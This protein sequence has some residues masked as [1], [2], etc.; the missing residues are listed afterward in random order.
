[1]TSNN[2]FSRF[3]PAGRG[4][5]SFYEELR[6]DEGHG[7]HGGF[8]VEDGAGLALD[9]ENLNEQF[10]DYDLDHADGLGI[11]G[12]RTTVDEGAAAGFGGQR[13]AATATATTAAART[14]RE[15]TA[16]TTAARGGTAAR[17]L[18][19]PRANVSRS[20]WGTT[21]AGG[22]GGGGTGDE[23]G[24]NDDVPGSLLVE[25][26]GM[27]NTPL[28]PLLKATPLRS[29]ASG[30]SRHFPSS[31]AGDGPLP[32]GPTAMLGGGTKKRREQWEAT[33]NVQRLYG[34]DLDDGGAVGGGGGGGLGLRAGLGSGGGGGTGGGSGGGGGMPGHALLSYFFPSGGSR[35]RSTA[36][37]RA[38]WRWVNVSNLDNFIRD[39]YDYYRDCGLRCIL[40]ERFLHL[41]NVAFVAVF[42]TFLT[43]CI[44]YTKI[45]GSTT[46][47]QILVPQC[48]R[49]MSWLWNVGLWLFAFYFVWKLMQFFIFDVRRLLHLRD[50][51]VHLLQIPEHD[52]QTVSWQDVVVKIMALRDQNP[53]TATNLTRRQRDWVGSQSK[54]RLDAHDIA[55]RLMRRENYL[56]ALFNKDILDLT[57]PLPF[58]RR[59]SSSSSSNSKKQ[60]LTRTLEWTLWFGVLDFVF[61]A[62]GQ[63][64][65][66]F[67][68]ASRRSQ[69]SQ[70]LKSRF[71]FAGFMNLLLAPFVACY[72]VVVYFLT[73]YNEYQKNPS[74]LGARAYTPLAEWK[75]REFNELE[76]LFEER[77]NMSYPFA[78]RYLD[79]F[80]KRKTEQVAKTVAF[81]AGSVM[82]VLAIASLFDPELFLGFEITHDRT[83]L[84]Y[85]G[86]FA[87]VWAAARGMITEE[88]SVFD[89]EYALRNVIEYTHYE[90]D[91]WKGR[92]HSYDVK[93]EFAELYQIKIK[94]FLEEIL[95]IFFTPLILFTSLPRSSDQIIDF[96]REFT[97]HVDG[98]GY[99]CSF[100]VFD[101]HKGVGGGTAK[102]RH[103]GPPP[104]EQQQ[105][106]QQQQQQ[107]QEPQ[108]QLQPDPLGANGGDVRDDY[109]A[110]K[111]GKMA[112]SYYGF[113]DNYV[114]NPKTGIPGHHP[115]GSAAAR[116]HHHHHHAQFHPPPAFPGL[117]SP[118]LAADMQSSILRNRKGAGSSVAALRTPRFGPTA[119]VA[120]PSPMASILLDPHHQPSASALFA[121]Q[122]FRAAAAAPGVV[123]GA[124][125]GITSGRY[126]AGVGG[127]S[128]IIEES[129]TE[130]GS[131][132]TTGG[133]PRP[134]SH[135]DDHEEP[136]PPHS[137]EGGEHSG[138]AL[139]DESTWQ[140]SPPTGMS[141]ENSSSS[142]GG[143]GDEA[144]VGVLG[145]MYQFQQAH[146]NHRMGGVR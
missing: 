113:L 123:G 146:K 20:R 45:R 104:H 70:M 75:F 67:L 91:H 49:H 58:L 93:V 33:Q 100:A 57:I 77:L 144:D 42:L 85:V 52:M 64:N 106:Q 134:T 1:M 66:E 136:L 143:V 108:S 24:D 76:H 86:I 18:G 51:Y 139:L 34:D 138:T 114:I 43:Q 109:Y 124:A 105:Q 140:T 5:R 41:V 119:S 120:Q 94:I 7:E 48:T 112:A 56:I 31:R 74:A 62:R 35:R 84:F 26:Q 133:G 73:Y 28:P 39:V 81:V 4:G 137:S 128:F 50:F 90:P 103:L 10:H 116:H 3:G 142:T 22:G 129:T 130:D 98:L 27:Q 80:P 32:T 14:T 87:T 47:H 61:D 37:D 63:V 19:P 82:T 6:S 38:M 95:S 36:H 54:E 110:T 16:T 111:H 102:Q 97:V 2:L 15:T 126:G 46:M 92:L 53:K 141:R 9:E 117:N 59:L 145:L 11:D 60:L 107:P 69:L 121:N 88:N 40:L 65:Q 30:R 135:L 78:T 29:N 101:F 44:D 118:T 131:A 99:V 127:D 79:Q 71:L 132:A 68:K 89:P 115:P 12:S 72:L 55:N 122:R 25:A 23:D 83:V 125:G 8:D 17:L 21:T 96:F 13:A